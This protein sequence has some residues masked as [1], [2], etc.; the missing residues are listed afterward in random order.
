MPMLSSLGLARDARVRW[1]ILA[2]EEVLPLVPP[3]RGRGRA[4]NEFDSE[5]GSVMRRTHGAKLD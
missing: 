2:L 4:G 3:E 1:N 5:A